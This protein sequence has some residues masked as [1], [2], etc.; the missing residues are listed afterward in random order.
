MFW[1][2]IDIL[3]IFYWQIFV[4]VILISVVNV[5]NA[6][7]YVYMQFNE[8]SEVWIVTVQFFW[9]R[10]KAILFYFFANYLCKLWLKMGIPYEVK[11][12]FKYNIF[13]NS[14]GHLFAVKSNNASRMLGNC[15]NISCQDIWCNNSWTQ[16][17][18]TGFKHPLG[19]MADELVTNLQAIYE[20]KYHREKNSIRN[21]YIY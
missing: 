16:S 6:A 12:N 3:L 5:V 7:I 15:Q 20:S 4:Q 17:T 18:N 2:F 1:F 21:V 9:S 8:I 10:I 14:A 11:K 13:R 19:N